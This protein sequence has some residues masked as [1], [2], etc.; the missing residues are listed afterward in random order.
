MQAAGI[1]V[2]RIT[3]ET[4]TIQPT[5]F[6][7]RLKVDMLYLPFLLFKDSKRQA[8]RYCYCTANNLWDRKGFSRNEK[9]QR[10][11]YDNPL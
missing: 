4:P 2:T 9:V 10:H 3:P 11:K 8:T 1:S 6:Q 5:S 7:L